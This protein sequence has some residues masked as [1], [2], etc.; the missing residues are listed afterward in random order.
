MRIADRRLHKY[1]IIR[2]PKK[3][4]LLRKISEEIGNFE[5]WGKEFRAI[6]MMRAMDRAVLYRDALT[7]RL[8]NFWIN[9]HIVGHP[10]GGTPL[11]ILGV[12]EHAFLIDEGLKRGPITFRLFS[13][14]S[15]GR[16][17][18]GG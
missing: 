6:G 14:I 4:K 7:G 5:T 11:L 15:I 12:F 18:R 9:E 2:L 17:S 16:S 10:A 1:S 8:F 3:P 13:G